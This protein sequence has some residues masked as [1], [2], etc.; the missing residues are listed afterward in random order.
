TSVVFSSPKAA[1]P[2]SGWLAVS[3]PFDVQI[4]DNDDL[5]G[6]SGSARIMLQA[7]RHEF[8]FVNQALGYDDT[9]R[10]DIG[11]GKQSAVKIDAPKAAL[12]ANAKPWADVIIAGANVGQTPLAHLTLPNR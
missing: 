7:G 5:V 10:V 6:T 2:A 8:R 4:F 1:G 11:A 12:S 9:R 3:A